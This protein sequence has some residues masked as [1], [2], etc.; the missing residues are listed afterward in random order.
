MV[1]L[2]APLLSLQAPPYI[3]S[4]ASLNPKDCCESHSNPHLPMECLESPSE[5]ISHFRTSLNLCWVP[6]FRPSL[7]RNHPPFPGEIWVARPA[8]FHPPGP[9]PSLPRP[10]STAPHGRPS[11][12]LRSGLRRPRGPCP[13]P[14]GHAGPAPATRRLGGKDWRHGERSHIFTRNQI[15]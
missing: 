14:A 9:P 5:I 7:S 11:W 4:R 3:D 15:K 6:P 8:T 10:T 2:V 12:P 1:G 13:G